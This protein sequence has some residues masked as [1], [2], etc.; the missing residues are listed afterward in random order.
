MQNHKYFTL[1]GEVVFR[2]AP[3]KIPDAYYESAY[4]TLKCHLYDLQRD[5]SYKDTYDYF[6]I[7]TFKAKEISKI[8]EGYTVSCLVRRDGNLWMKEGKM[9][10][11]FD[12][13]TRN[14]EKVNFGTMPVL[15]E[16]YHLTG[17]IMVTDN[18][19]D[20]ESLKKSNENF[21]GFLEDNQVD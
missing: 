11:K 20:N 16:S 15:F 21:E 13:R 4:F 2:G 8:R 17:E 1:T 6:T 9:V 12:M 19:I 5:G 18:S 7:H 10:T 14:G 3:V